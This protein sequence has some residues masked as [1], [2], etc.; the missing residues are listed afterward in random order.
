MILQFLIA[1][2]A[3]ATMP[4]LATA[5]Q[6]RKFGGRTTYHGKRANWGLWYAMQAANKMLAHPRNGGENS[7]VTWYQGS[8]SGAAASA[9]TH[10]GSGTFDC[11]PYNWKNRLW[12]FR[13][14]GF[15]IWMRPRR[16]GLWVQHMHAVMAGDGGAAASAIRQVVAF[17]RRPSRDGL[18][19]NRVDTQLPRMLCRPLFVY[20]LKA[21]GKPGW[22]LCNIT[23]GAYEQQTTAAKRVDTVNEGEK[24]EVVAVTRDRDTGKYW[25]LTRDRK[26][27]FLD[28]FERVAA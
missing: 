22:F 2:V 21:V 1:A 8:W 11:T 13:L 26:A 5:V 15:A 25:G 10:R 20:P 27:I 28:N 7:P 3:I 4:S 6:D 23:C 12:V 9:G 16:A 17:W 19:G 18:A 14:L 24:W